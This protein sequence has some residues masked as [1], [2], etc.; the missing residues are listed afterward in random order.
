[1]MVHFSWHAAYVLLWALGNQL[2]FACNA[3]IEPAQTP[4]LALLAVFSRL[5]SRY[6]PLSYRPPLL[7]LLCANETSNA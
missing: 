6:Y 2:V 3:N 4:H 5:P 1:M 7:C